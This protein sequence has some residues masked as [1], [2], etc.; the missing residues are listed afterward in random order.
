M[1][2]D[3]HVCIV[4]TIASTI[5]AH[6]ISHANYIIVIRLLFSVIISRVRHC[7]RVITPRSTWQVKWN[8]LQG[9]VHLK[10][11]VINNM[12]TIIQGKGM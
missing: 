9:N 7:Y 10:V 1:P 12:Y 3:V 4:L 11:M 8:V 2:I 6:D 5:K